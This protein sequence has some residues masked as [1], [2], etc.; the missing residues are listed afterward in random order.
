MVNSAQ[1]A[2][3]SVAAAQAGLGG[4]EESGIPFQHY[5]GFVYPTYDPNA[6]FS[7]HQF[8]D[9]TQLLGVDR[10]IG[11]GQSYLASP[12]SD[13]Y[14]G[15]ISSSTASPEPYIASSSSTP[16]S[17]ESSGSGAGSTSR[18]ITGRK[19]STSKR[20]SQDSSTSRST[21]VLSPPAFA[22]RKSLVST[23][24]GSGSGS[25]MNGGGSGSSGNVPIRQAGLRSETST[26]DLG[27]ASAQSVNGTAGSTSGED[28]DQVP[29]VCTN[30]QTTN[31]PLWRR[32]PDGQPL[33][34]Y[35]VI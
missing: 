35:C 23:G 27:N 3:N 34:E 18:T 7:Q 13:G 26:P 5:L 9:P 8:I 19:I 17:T 25:G 4:L 28:G 29:T 15:I 33:C 30:C 10:D 20:L 1:R 22:A 11:Q 6:G 12:S 31:T 16:P 2:A 21:G 24:R 32:D 14:G